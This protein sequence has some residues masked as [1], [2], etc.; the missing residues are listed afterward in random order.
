MVVRCLKCLQ[1]VLFKHIECSFQDAALA[2]V[3]SCMEVAYRRV[4]GLA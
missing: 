1:G 4:S 2:V 3:C